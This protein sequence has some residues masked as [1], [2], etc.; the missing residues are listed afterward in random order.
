MLVKS[1]ICKFNNMSAILK[2]LVIT[3]L[4]EQVFQWFHIAFLNYIGNSVQ[5]T[6]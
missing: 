1:Q 6:I 4:V 2:M 5:N 3:F